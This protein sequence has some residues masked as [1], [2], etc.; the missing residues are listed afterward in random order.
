MNMSIT[1]AE[2]LE[3]EEANDL[4]IPKNLDSVALVCEE[5]VEDAEIELTS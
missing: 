3:V 1:N 2:A 5:L 4:A